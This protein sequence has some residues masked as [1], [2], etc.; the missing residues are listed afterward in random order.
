[1]GRD[2]DN[3][4]T[5]VGRRVDGGGSGHTQALVLVE[6]AE[7]EVKGNEVGVHEQG[8]GLVRRGEI[9]RVVAAIVRGQGISHAPQDR[10]GR[11]GRHDGAAKPGWGSGAQIQTGR[12]QKRGRGF[13]VRK[14][15]GKATAVWKEEGEDAGGE[16]RAAAEGPHLGT[17]L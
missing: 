14:T 1:M 4:P 8:D 11:D 5:E 9:G 16:A 12:K 2:G 7:L 3:R 6:A 10:E 13:R 17:S 15:T